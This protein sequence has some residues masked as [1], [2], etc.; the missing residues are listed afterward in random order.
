LRLVCSPKTGPSRFTG[1]QMPFAPQ[2]AEQ[3][4]A[5]CELTRETDISEQK[6]YRVKKKFGGQ[7]PSEAREPGQLEEEIVWPRLA[8]W[9]KFRKS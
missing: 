9:R 5:R 3:G 8:G 4:T 2:Q 1:Q 7:M 6:F